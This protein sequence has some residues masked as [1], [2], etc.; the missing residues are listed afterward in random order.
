MSA[1]WHLAQAARAL[2]AGGVVAYPT[3]AVY[4]LGCEPLDGEAVLRLL[5]MKRRSVDKGLI[6][7]A[8]DYAQLRP[9]VELPNAELERRVR[10]RWPGPTTWLLPAR[11]GVPGWI[12]GGR[13]SLAVRVTAHPLAAALC[14]RYGAPLVSSSAN[15]SGGRPARD[16]L[17]VRRRF[18]AQLDYVLCGRTGALAAPTEIR[19]A[20]SGRL[21][22]AGPAPGAER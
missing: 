20:L 2:R 1:G 3:E 19:D 5:A 17:G 12:T 18:G 22:R 16:A 10:A 14:A 21:L 6:L 15:L 7:I 13:P 11:A 4:G 9:W 8:S